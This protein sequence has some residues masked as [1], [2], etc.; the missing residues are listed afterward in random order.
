M[1]LPEP[2]WRGLEVFQ[3]ENDACTKCWRQ[4]RPSLF[5]VGTL[6]FSVIGQSREKPG[7]FR[8]EN[9]GP[10]EGRGSRRHRGQHS[11]LM[12]E[13]PGFKSHLCHLLPLFNLSV[14]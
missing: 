8:E 9:M 6:G 10:S 12:S 14:H 2:T 3:G 4:S 11:M 7:M 13:R 5:Q 1:K